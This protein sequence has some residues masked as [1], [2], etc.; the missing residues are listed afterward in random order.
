MAIIGLAVYGSRARQDDAA[1]ADIDLLAVTTDRTSAAAA[2]DTLTISSYPLGQIICRAGLGDL[3]VLHIATEA[4]VIYE[5][6]PVFEHIQRAFK[7][8]DDYAR[9]IRLASDV[10]WFLV[11]YQ[12]RFDDT[13]RFNESMAW[14]ARTILIAMA[15]NHRRPLFSAQLLSEFVDSP[16]VL[17][18]IKNKDNTNDAPAVV[19]RFQSF[20]RM[21]GAEEP[22][23]ARTLEEQKARFDADRNARGSRVV[24]AVAV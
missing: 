13:K 11:R 6:W 20:L 21:F 23:P 22:P 1:D 17:T 7:Y 3:F 19:D 14:C 9:E 16:D 12:A 4:K 2:H 15:A 8:K 10:G 18:I 24:R 5:A